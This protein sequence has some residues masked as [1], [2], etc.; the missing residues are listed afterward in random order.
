MMGCSQEVLTSNIGVSNIVAINITAM[1]SRYHDQPHHAYG[2][3][4]ASKISVPRYP[5]EKE[6][7]SAYIKPVTKMPV[8]IDF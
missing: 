1:V 3:D 6:K 8:R 2:S 7:P 5:H 4:T